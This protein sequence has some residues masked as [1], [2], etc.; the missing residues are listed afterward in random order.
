MTYGAEWWEVRKKDE[1][2]LHLT[3][4]RIGPYYETEKITLL[5]T[6]QEKIRRQPLKKMM[7]MVVVLE[8]D[9]DDWPAKMWRWTLK[10]KVEKVGHPLGGARDCSCNGGGSTG[11]PDSSLLSGSTRRSIIFH[12]QSALLSFSA[13]VRIIRAA[14]PCRDNRTRYLFF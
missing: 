1:N 6:H 9:G 10:V 8:N 3:E 11:T 2:R 5:W 4:M 12:R 7:D 14:Q 13:H